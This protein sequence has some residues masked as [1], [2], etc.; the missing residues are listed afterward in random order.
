MRPFGKQR[1]DGFG[2]GCP[3]GGVVGR[4]QRLDDHDVAPVGADHSGRQM[5]PV[6][7]DTA[8][9]ALL[10]RD[11]LGVEAL[12]YAEALRIAVESGRGGLGEVVDDRAGSLRRKPAGPVQQ[13][14]VIPDE[15]GGSADRVP[16]PS[17]AGRRSVG[18]SVATRNGA[19]DRVAA[20]L[21]PELL[22]SAVVGGAQ[23]DVQRGPLVLGQCRAAPRLAEQQL[24]GD[25]EFGHRRDAGNLLVAVG[26]QLV[27]DTVEHRDRDGGADGGGLVGGLLNTGGQLTE[28]IGGRLRR[29]EGLREPGDL[30]GARRDRLGARRAVYLRLAGGHQHRHH[31]DGGDEQHRRPRW[32]APPCRCRMHN[33]RACRTALRR[34]IAGSAAQRQRPAGALPVQSYETI[35]RAGR[36]VAPRSDSL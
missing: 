10:D 15:V 25:E 18:Q 2:D 14:P 23:H 12:G 8:H 29:Q 17:V 13:H 24:V 5:H 36:V 27:G 21:V 26:D 1:L 6:L 22:G 19:D 3:R 11:G 28:A 20:Q 31:C 35:R 4:L 32:H 34:R 16:P 30:R 7:A 33:S 9:P